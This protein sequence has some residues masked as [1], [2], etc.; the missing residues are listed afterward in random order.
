MAEPE[1]KSELR[2]QLDRIASDIERGNGI[3]G[4]IDYARQDL[5]HEVFEAVEAAYKRGHE[6]GSSRAGYRL[7]QEN[8]RLRRELEDVQRHY[9]IAAKAIGRARDLATQWAVLRAY[10][11][12]AYELRKAIDKEGD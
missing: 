10:G 7:T 9:E 4:G 3:Q 6:A 2:S 5:E 11:G 8:E 1:W 12:A